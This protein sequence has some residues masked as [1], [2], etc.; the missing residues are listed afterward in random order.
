MNALKF[1]L[2]T[3][4]YSGLFP[5]TP[6]TAGSFVMLLPLYFLLQF[7]SIW[8]ILLI[9]AAGCLICLWV[10][11]YFEEKYGKD[12]GVLVMDEWA[13]Q[14][15]TFLTIP[16]VGTAED[17]IIIL[18]TGFVLFRFFDLLKPLGVKNMQDLPGGWGIF[19]DDLLAGLYALLCLKTLIFV[20]PNIFGMA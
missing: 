13:G 19:V 15:L 4:F 14:S 7:N 6:G 20:W 3:G 12:P 8:L 5:K 9:T 17:H 10:A 18:L 16:F 2:G 1:L 11:D